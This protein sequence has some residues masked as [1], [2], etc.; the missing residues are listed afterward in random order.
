MSFPANRRRLKTVG[1]LQTG[2]DEG[3]VDT[4]GDGASEGVWGDGRGL[5]GAES[6][7]APGRP[8][9]GAAWPPPRPRLRGPP[10]KGTVPGMAIPLTPWAR[11]DSPGPHQGRERGGA[12]RGRALPAPLF[13]VAVKGTRAGGTQAAREGCLRDP[14]YSLFVP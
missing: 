12:G 6:S 1:N 7:G 10:A 5:G 8:L 11:Q 3:A 13:A 9:H 2:L 4:A 14:L